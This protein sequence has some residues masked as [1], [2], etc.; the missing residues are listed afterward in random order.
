[1]FYRVNVRG[2]CRPD[3]HL[4]VIVFKPLCSQLGGMF[5]VIVLLED[6]LS[7]SHLQLVKAFL[8]SILQNLTILLCIHDPLNLCELAYS[9]PPHTTPYHKVISSSMLNSRCDGSV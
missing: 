9:I 4:D 1:M 8:H 6:P 3:K 7:F 5:G 2:L